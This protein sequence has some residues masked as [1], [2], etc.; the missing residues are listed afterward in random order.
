MLSPSKCKERCGISSP[1]YSLHLFS[2]WKKHPTSWR[3]AFLS[4]HLGKHYTPK[5]HPT[6]VKLDGW[7]VWQIMLMLLSPHTSENNLPYSTA[8]CKQ[9]LRRWQ[10][11]FHKKVTELKKL[12]HQNGYFTN[13]H[14]QMAKITF[15]TLNPL[16]WGY[17]SGKKILHPWNLT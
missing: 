14:P 16:K 11:T 10:E 5:I 15:Q 7:W 13:T 6:C 3:E 9:K 17:P 1:F 12:N 4:I 2:G 8:H